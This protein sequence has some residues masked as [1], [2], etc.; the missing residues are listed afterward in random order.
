MNDDTLRERPPLPH[1]RAVCIS[2][3]G[4]TVVL[5]YHPTPDAVGPRVEQLVTI[6]PGE[7][8]P[9]AIFITPPA[10]T[11][12]EVLRRRG[13]KV[14][15][16]VVPLP[17]DLVQ[18]LLAQVNVHIAPY[19]KRLSVRTALQQVQVGIGQMVAE[20][21]AIEIDPTPEEIASQQAGPTLSIVEGGAAETNGKQAE[22]ASSD[23]LAREN[24][25]AAPENVAPVVAVQLVQV[26]ADA[27]LRAKHFLQR[28]SREE[29]LR[30]AAALRDSRHASDVEKEVVL[31][32]Q[33]DSQPGFHAELDPPD[34]AGAAIA[35]EQLA[36]DDPFRAA[37]ARVAIRAQH[38]PA[39]NQRCSCGG[40][41]VYVHR[42]DGGE[43][44]TR[45]PV[46]VALD[47]YEDEL[48]AA[49]AID[50]A[51][52]DDP[53]LVQMYRQ[54][55]VGEPADGLSAEERGSAAMM[56][57][58]P[59]REAPDPDDRDHELGAAWPRDPDDK[60]RLQEAR[61]GGDPAVTEHLRREYEREGLLR[62][63][64]PG[65][66]RDSDEL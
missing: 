28:V 39:E 64:G 9:S 20:C 17:T 48:R 1:D 42:T 47:L 23:G 15:I 18:Y 12:V 52:W 66:G 8:V 53:A 5:A 26:F 13:C 41:M 21:I 19:G 33:G 10:G 6:D 46:I 4:P 55:C 58:G 56:E 51:T 34:V 63:I 3:E 50:P 25:A 30:K 2:G 62:E 37:E 22:I 59:E 35:E 60:P 43:S 16:R 27:A 65:P 14:G 44:G 29:L 57:A 7:G 24:E 49:A 38:Q 61:G 31:A 54:R 40:T 36:R 45:C 11:T 32:L